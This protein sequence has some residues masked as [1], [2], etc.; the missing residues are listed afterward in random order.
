MLRDSLQRRR[1]CGDASEISL[2]LHVASRTAPPSR[3]AKSYWA[4]W[5]L[6]DE[7]AE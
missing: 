7:R 6:A 1:I 2:E 3:L 5:Q 4:S